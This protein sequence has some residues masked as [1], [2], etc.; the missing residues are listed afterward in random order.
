MCMLVIGGNASKG[1]E[2][3]SITLSLKLLQEASAHQA[4]WRHP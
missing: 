1:V 3:T 2:A 4:F